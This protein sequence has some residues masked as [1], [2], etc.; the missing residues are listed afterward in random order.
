MSKYNNAKEFAANGKYDEAID[1][2]ND[3]ESFSDSQKQIYVAMA[4]AALDNN[5]Y[6]SGIDY[7]KSIGGKTNITYEANGGEISEN[8]TISREGYTFAGWIVKEYSID[9]RK[10]YQLNLVLVAN[11]DA[12]MYSISYDLAGGI[13][14]TNSLKTAYNA[15]MEVSIPNIRK[16]GYIFN[17]WIYDGNS[18]PK[19]DLV[20]SKGTTGNISLKA[21]WTPIDYYITFNLN[22]GQMNEDSKLGVS[23]N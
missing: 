22:S 16:E 1:I 10:N 3:I 15:D 21:V 6:Q 9:D 14:E 7:I 12:I 4:S 18:E 5:D 17:G 19:K 23:Y 13:Y 11:W 2:F 20:I 8:N